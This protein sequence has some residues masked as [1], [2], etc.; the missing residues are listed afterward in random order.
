MEAPAIAEDLAFT[1]EALQKAW[2]A[3]AEQRKMYLAEYQLLT[4]PYDR[5]DN[6]VILHLHNPIQETILNTIK[7]DLI[8]FLR[9]SLQNKSITLTGE[10]R[11]IESRKILYTNRE[12][13]DFLVEKYPGLKELRD[14]LGLDTDF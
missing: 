10:T 12:K 1:D 5:R 9:K 14:R 4:Q 3:F 7:S 2:D 11:E 6:E 13:F 8:A